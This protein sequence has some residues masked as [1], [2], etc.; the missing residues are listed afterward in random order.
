MVI[1]VPFSLQVA[2]WR[3]PVLMLGFVFVVFVFVH[4]SRL[5]FRLLLSLGDG[6]V[7]IGSQLYCFGLAFPTLASDSC[8]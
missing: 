2:P 4:A 6:G 1:P 7:V 8:L 3:G 5:L